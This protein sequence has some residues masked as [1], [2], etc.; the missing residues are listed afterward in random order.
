LLLRGGE[1]VPLPHI[2][3][4]HVDLVIVYHYIVHLK[5]CFFGALSVIEF[6]IVSLR[7]T[8]KANSFFSVMSLIDPN[9]EKF[10]FIFKSTPYHKF[11]L[12]RQG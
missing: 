7:I 8:I 10:L 9:L 4:L 1:V 2:G 5:D 11:F 12:I 6:L 3:L